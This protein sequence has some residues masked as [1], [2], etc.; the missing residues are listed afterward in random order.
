[1]LCRDIPLLEFTICKISRDEHSID[2]LPNMSYSCRSV[3]QEKN[4]DIQNV[5]GGNDVIVVS[6][7][8]I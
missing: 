1:M 2:V 3:V 7:E 6:R 5:F 8:A 4:H